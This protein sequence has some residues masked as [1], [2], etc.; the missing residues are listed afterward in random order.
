V[1]A[2]RPIMLLVKPLVPVPSDVLLLAVVGD[3]LVSQHTPRAVIIAPPSLVKLPPLVAVVPVILLI[4]IVVMEGT[5]ADKVV[6]VCSFPYDV[7]AALVAYARI[8]YVVLPESPVI[9]LVK[10]LA[11]LPSVV[12]LLPVVGIVLVPQ[13]TPRTVTGKHPSDVTL[14]PPVAPVWIIALT[15]AVVTVGNNSEA[16]TPAAIKSEADMPACI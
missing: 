5:I 16:D 14:P 11:P 3:V 7:P 2:V 1:P 8:R 10:L 15:L 13:H 9:L 6:K 12:L 4:P